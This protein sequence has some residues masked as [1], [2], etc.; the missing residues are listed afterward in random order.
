MLSY[1]IEPLRHKKTFI[2][3]NVYTE[4]GTVSANV[5]LNAVTEKWPLGEKR[6]ETGFFETRTY[7]PAKVLIFHIP[8]Y[9]NKSVL[10]TARQTSWK[11]FADAAK[12][13]LFDSDS[14]AELCEIGFPK[15]LSDSD[16]STMVLL[17]GRSRTQ[18]DAERI[19]LAEEKMS[20]AEE[21]ADKSGW[22]DTK[23]KDE[24][25]SDLKKY[26]CYYAF[27]DRLNKMQ[28]EIS[29][30]WVR[31]SLPEYPKE[32][33]V[34]YNDSIF[35]IKNFRK[36][37]HLRNEAVDKNYDE[38]LS[39]SV[40]LGLKKFDWTASTECWRL[41]CRNIV[42][43]DYGKDLVLKAFDLKDARSAYFNSF[44]ALK[45]LKNELDFYFKTEQE[46]FSKEADEF[47]DE[48]LSKKVIL[49]EVR[50]VIC[51]DDDGNI[52]FAEYD[53]SYSHLKFRVINKDN[54]TDKLTVAIA[55]MDIHQNTIRRTREQLSKSNIYIA[56]K[57]KRMIN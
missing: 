10:E 56:V 53:P 3:T 37:P 17:S 49:N 36:R 33:Y 31:I 15:N 46:K 24:L 30:N 25:V 2:D 54:V 35:E 20:A 19:R 9:E 5:G 57:K 42:D 14:Y 13:G 18:V 51:Q 47:Y 4:Y 11:K 48:L 50:R 39:W 26:G 32:K 21:K 7:G 12:T 29:E 44:K 45:E 38:D 52:Y 16:I 6:T 55:A 23:S 43:T 34:F 28:K 8:E 27:A 40:T 41:N 1:V 22:F